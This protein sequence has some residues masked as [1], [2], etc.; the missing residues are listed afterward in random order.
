MGNKQK[1]LV[2]ESEL[3]ITGLRLVLMKKGNFGSWCRKCC[4]CSL[5]FLG[6]CGQGWLS[7]PVALL[8]SLRVGSKSLDSSLLHTEVSHIDG[9]VVP[10]DTLCYNTSF[11]L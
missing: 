2:G 5:R 3:S 6:H 7:A 1:W 11:S 8:L 10:E 9:G 4:L